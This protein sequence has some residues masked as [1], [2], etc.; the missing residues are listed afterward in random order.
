MLAI[1]TDFW[2]DNHWIARLHP[3][4]SAAAKLETATVPARA[5]AGGGVL[6]RAR[7]E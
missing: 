2:F 1:D 4:C 6:L 5:L 7:T 3:P